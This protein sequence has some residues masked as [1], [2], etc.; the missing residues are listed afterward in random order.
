MRTPD[1]GLDKLES[2]E[3]LIGALK[4]IVKFLLKK[5]VPVHASTLSAWLMKSNQNLEMQVTNKLNN[6]FLKGEE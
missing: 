2:E 3:E 1:Q 4:M 5:N 6:C